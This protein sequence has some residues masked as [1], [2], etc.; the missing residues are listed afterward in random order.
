MLLTR[1]YFAFRVWRTGGQLLPDRASLKRE[2]LWTHVAGSMFLLL[3]VLV[4][5][6]LGGLAL[7]RR[8][9]LVR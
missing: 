4:I 1:F 7:V 3:L 5:L 8:H 2:G 6:R 9:R